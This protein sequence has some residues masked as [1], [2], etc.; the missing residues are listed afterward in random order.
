MVAVQT[1]RTG[2]VGE[3]EKKKK[4]KKRVKKE[5][6]QSAVDLQTIK[7]DVT[8]TRTRQATRKMGWKANPWSGRWM[9][10]GTGCFCGY[11]EACTRSFREE[12]QRGKG[13]FS[14]RRKREEN[15][16]RG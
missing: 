3:G 11:D 9:W 1:P 8:D 4:G 13:A 5:K 12:T 6:N 15:K 10:E 14:A 16:G 7:E 2:D